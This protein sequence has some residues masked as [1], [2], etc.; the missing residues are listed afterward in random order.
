MSPFHLAQEEGWQRTS[1]PWF[2]GNHVNDISVLKLDHWFRRSNLTLAFEKYH[3]LPEWRRLPVLTR[4]VKAGKSE[5]TGDEDQERG[6]EN[7][8][9]SLIRGQREKRLPIPRCTRWDGC[10]SGTITRRKPLNSPVQRST[11]SNGQS[12]GEAS[13]EAR[14]ACIPN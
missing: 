12:G 7:R 2:I 6:S 5:E 11:G 1:S 3:R 10:Q 8:R 14:P 4:S 13:P 9:P